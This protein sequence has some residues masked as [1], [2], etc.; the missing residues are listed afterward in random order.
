MSDSSADRDPI[1]R[2]A[3]SFLARFR[4]GERPSI[5]EYAAKYP[6]LADQIRELLPAL[7][8][9]E[10]DLAEGGGAT[11]AYRG[12]VAASSIPIPRQLDDY[13]ILREIGRGGM[14]T[15][16]EAVQQSLGRQVALKV[17]PAQGLGGSSHLERFRL[18]ARAVARLHHTNIVPVYGV[19]EYEGVHYYAMQFIQGQGLDVIFDEVR[20]L[21]GGQVPA[22]GPARR[23]TPEAAR[24]LAFTLAHSLL[25]GRFATAPAE[26]AATR[27]ETRADGMDG[28]PPNASSPPPH[29]D[30]RTAAP[31][32]SSSS[33]SEMAGQPEASYFRS[34]ARI[35]IQVAEA[36]AYAHG[37]GILHRDIK[38]SNLLMDAQGRVWVT[39]FG[40][41]KAEGSEGPTH[42]GDIVGTLRYMAPERFD[43]WSD[44]R[45][46]VYALGATL[47]EM[48]TLRPVYEESNRAR[49]IE[50][51][52]R[53]DP[54]PPRKLDR[55]I[56]RDLETMVL[57]AMAKES[58]ARYATAEGLADDLRRFV[59]HRPIHARRISTTERL[60][61]W[62]R[63]NPVVACLTAAVFVLLVTVAI[64][65]SVSAVRFEHLAAEAQHQ[66]VVA[67]HQAAEAKTQRELADTSTREANQKA[68]ALRRQDYIS[69]VNLAYRECL[70]NN[71]A[72]ALE[73]LD[74]CPHD[75]RGWEWSYVR[76]QCHLD[77]HTFNEPAPSVNCVAFSPDGKRVASG[78]GEFP[79]DPRRRA[80]DLVVRDAATGQEVFSRRGLPGGVSTVAFSPDGRWLASG[81]ASDLA[82]WDTATG[83]ERFRKES[84]PLPILSL[85]FSPDGTRIVAGYGRF[86]FS[87]VTG[88]AKLWD[89]TTGEEVIDKLPGHPGGVWSV[90]FSPDGRQ[91]ALSSSDLVEV[92]DLE[93][94]KP[95]LTLRGHTGLLYTVAFSPDGRYLA[96]GGLD[97]TIKLWDRTTGREVRTCSGHEGFI[98]GL[99]FSPDGQQLVSA[100]EDNTLKLW[101]VTSDR[102]L[103]TFH[104]HTYYVNCVA[105][106]PDGRLFASGSVDQT[107][108]L[109]F[110]TPNPQLSYPGHDGWVY[111][112]A[113]SPDGQHVATGSAFFATGH[114]LQ[115][116]HAATG[117][118]LL[119]FPES[120]SRVNA[121]AFSPGGRRLAS[122]N[123][124]GTVQV[125]DAVTGRNVLTLPGH[126]TCVSAAT[127][128]PDDQYLASASGE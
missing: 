80:G 1:E 53:E 73:L 21:R 109:W 3:D 57:K 32:L 111:A 31:V 70:D 46:D 65:A 91:V 51:V 93:T 62:S 83:Q 112:V 9:I 97:R 81:N 39:D 55:R 114:F 79:G 128:S 59:E 119:S 37:Q 110:A 45:S 11:G 60:W 43:G 30:D 124:D 126:S 16:Y 58:G 75:L 61:R 41:A 104:G 108:K 29:S 95:N 5:D 14:G 72:R 56:P 67:E 66:A 103:A 54:M 77:L 13:L 87:D 123:W 28:S 116:W 63:R 22:G 40:L 6:E 121:V 48:L 24:S 96:S 7:V 71:V 42:T 98:R 101:K 36:L 106:S 88:Y 19:G 38:P 125:W 100:S 115:V 120:Q 74:G 34:I 118:Q 15:V 76:R 44:P 18:E 86:N 12:E 50:R 127:F 2:L 10:Q 8:L 85:A 99:A 122:A 27:A 82:L 78:S 117:E 52:L 69:R 89:A 102:E 92:W 90:A 23:A 20:R 33:H 84:G 107:L 64:G 68:D 94:R 105:Y 113:F 47:Y 17:L 26:L 25:T 49:L 4:A 35:G